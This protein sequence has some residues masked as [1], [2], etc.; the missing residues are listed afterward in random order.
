MKRRCKMDGEPGVLYNIVLGEEWL[1]YLKQE[2]WGRNLHRKLYGG[3]GDELWRREGLES[4][5]SRGY[6]TIYC[7]FIVFV[8][9]PS[10][11]LG[12]SDTFSF[13]W[14]VIWSGTEYDHNHGDMK[15]RIFIR[16]EDPWHFLRLFCRSTSFVIYFDLRWINGVCFT[17]ASTTEAILLQK[18]LFPSKWFNP[19]VTVSRPLTPYLCRW[20]KE[21][22]TK[23][24]L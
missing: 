5:L 21:T 18:G 2:G 13:C 14:I 6:S 23:S 1:V 7:L 17:P 22:E 16:K 24:K 4:E 8:Y 19:P 10:H 9:H 20:R 12:V 11:E 15:I 3:E